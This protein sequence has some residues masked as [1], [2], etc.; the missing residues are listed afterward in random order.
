MTV[1]C[2]EE[3]GGKSFLLQFG[4]QIL[5]D[6]KQSLYSVQQPTHVNSLLMN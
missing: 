2:V 3:W 4:L 6:M 5:M 1:F